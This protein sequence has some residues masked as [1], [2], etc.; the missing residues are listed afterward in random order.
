MDI[1]PNIYICKI[2]KLK[3]KYYQFNVGIS[4]EKKQEVVVIIL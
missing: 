1:L 4:W 2:I 3:W